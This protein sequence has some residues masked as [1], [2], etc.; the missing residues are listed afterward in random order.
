MQ[1]YQVRAR[2]SGE[3]QAYRLP[4]LLSLKLIE[5]QQGRWT[6]RHESF[7]YNNNNN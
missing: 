2:N 7:H 5:G 3:Q 4:H 1:D 6:R